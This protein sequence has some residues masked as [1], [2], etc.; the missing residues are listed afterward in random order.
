MSGRDRAELNR[1]FGTTER[2]CGTNI[3]S[4]QLRALAPRDM[5]ALN[6]ASGCVVLHRQQ[7]LCRHSAADTGEACISCRSYVVFKELP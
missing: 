5:T 1:A 4:D 2:L 7:A 6:Q 3:P